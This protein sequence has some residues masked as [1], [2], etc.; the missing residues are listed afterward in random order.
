[1]AILVSANYP[2]VRAALD[3]HLSASDLPDDT[4][5]LIIYALAADQDVLNL[6]PDAESRTGEDANRVLRAAI[7][8]CAARLAPAVIKLT[9][10]SITTRDMS[11][12]K[13]A[14]DPD[15]RSAELR[16]MATDLINEIIEPTQTS[17]S[18]PVTFSRAPGIRGF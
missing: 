2:D 4:I 17:P 9:S 3:T 14:F 12:Q 15:E 18:R 7:F 5:A 8:F 1:M 10:L 11:Y 6:D 16:G 13:K